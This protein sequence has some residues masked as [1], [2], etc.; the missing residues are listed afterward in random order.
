VSRSRRARERHRAPRSRRRSAPRS[1]PGRVIRGCIAGP[2]R[3]R[4]AKIAEAVPPKRSSSPERCSEHVAPS[5]QSRRDSSAAAAATRDRRAIAS[6][7]HRLGRRGEMTAVASAISA[8][9]YCQD[10]VSSPPNAAPHFENKLSCGSRPSL[11][12][13]RR[14]LQLE[15]RHGRHRRKRVRL[16]PCREASLVAS[17]F[18]APA[19]ETA[20]ASW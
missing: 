4:P 14:G 15:L 3:S 16:A 17:V 13:R 8:I 18:A 12:C 7:A 9:S 20:L 6:R 10:A 5:A 1:R 11:G 19:S 2:M